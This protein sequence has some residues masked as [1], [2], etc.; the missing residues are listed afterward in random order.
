MPGWHV[1]GWDGHVHWKRNL[2]ELTDKGYEVG[3]H[4]NSS[5]NIIFIMRTNVK[6]GRIQRFVNLIALVDFGCFLF[7][8]LRPSSLR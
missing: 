4:H 3:E 5:F 1:R 2:V 8:S 7:F 6:P